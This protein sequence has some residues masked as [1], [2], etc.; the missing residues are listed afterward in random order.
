MSGHLVEASSQ[1]P[2]R[3]AAVRL[4]RD[5]AGAV[6]DEHGYFELE[7]SAAWVQDSLVVWSDDVRAAHWVTSGHAVGLRLAVALPPGR[8]GKWGY[9]GTQHAFRV[10]NDSLARGGTLRTASFY[11]GAGALPRKVFRVRLYDVAGNRP[12]VDVLTENVLML[13]W[14]ENQWFTV[15]L[16][17]YHLAVPDAGYF[18]ALEY[19]PDEGIRNSYFDSILV[20]YM[21]TGP[22][23]WPVCEANTRN[24][25][26]YVIGTGWKLL[27][28]DNG[29]YGRYGAMI[30]LE[31]DPPK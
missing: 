6:A 13:A 27:P 10:K 12:G 26:S 15:N 11:I 31:V 9:V 23:M 28:L 19:F 17:P 22:F 30:K 1:A 2:L 21:P 5:G 14:R 16:A 18:I 4:Q 20:D 25:W 29:L 8:E 3:F 7:S 24:V